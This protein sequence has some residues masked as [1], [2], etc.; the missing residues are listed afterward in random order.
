[1]ERAKQTRTVYLALSGVCTVLS[2]AWTYIYVWLWSEAHT[3]KRFDDALMIAPVLLFAVAAAMCFLLGFVP[4][5]R[6]GKIR[7]GIWAAAG[8]L[9]GYVIATG[10]IADLLPFE[11]D[12]WM[13]LASATLIPLL[14]ALAV[15]LGHKPHN[16]I[17]LKITRSVAAVLLI[18]AASLLGPI[19]ALVLFGEH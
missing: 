1:M 3:P 8:I 9:T 17:V 14:A 18:S 19:S 4:G 6:S 13:S 11:I 16:H 2:A 12:R 7:A 15:Q 10:S 5:S